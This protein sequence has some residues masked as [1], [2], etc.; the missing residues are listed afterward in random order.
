MHVRVLGS[1][2]GGGFPQWNCGCPNCTAVRAG[3]AR[4][5]A[6]TQASAAVT[7]DGE[8]WF[9]L[10]ASP[11]VRAQVDAFRPLHPRTGRGTPIAGI[12]LTSGDLDHCLGLLSLRESE[13]LVVYATA[14]VRRSFCDDNRLYR[15]LERFDG[16]VRWCDLE[17]GGAYD[18]VAG[19]HSAGLRLEV[20]PIPGTPPLHVAATSTPSDGDVVAVRLQDRRTGGVVVYAPGVAAVTP[21]LLDALDGAE[22]AFVDG[23]FWSSGELVNVTGGTRRAEDMGH[24]PLSGP[25]GTLAALRGIT[26]GR[27]VLTH[28]NNTNPVLRADSEERRIV[29]GEDWE[30]AFD[31]MELLA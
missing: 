27:R 4:F 6:R 7:A 18:L 16:Q 26:I 1:A 24:L 12:V 8:H 10:N 21:L 23:T 9:L 22:A 2:A 17:L 3:D 25:R 28:V 20:V 19:S 11:D 31:G 5:L 15:T 13:A 30:V 29:E 14:S